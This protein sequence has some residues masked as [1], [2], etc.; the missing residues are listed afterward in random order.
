MSRIKTVAVFASTVAI[1]VFALTALQTRDVVAHSEPATTSCA[2][3]HQGKLSF[4]G[5]D[6]QELAV[7]IHAVLNGE[8]RHPPLGLDDVSD[9]AIQQLAEQLAARK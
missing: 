5:K 1:A 8:I 6:S 9:A 4:A 7:R 2:N 3:C